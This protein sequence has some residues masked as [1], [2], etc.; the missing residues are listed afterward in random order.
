[1]RTTLTCCVLCL[2]F[3]VGMQTAA[4]QQYPDRTVR[5]I[6]GFGA[7][8]SADTTGR[9]VAQKLSERW[10]QQVIVDNR[11]GAAGVIGMQAAAKASRDG[12][13]LMIGSAT[14]FSVGPALG[15]GQ[16]QYP[17]ALELHP[18]RES[19]C[20]ANCV[21]CASVATGP[22][23]QRVHAVR[24]GPVWTDF[25]RIHGRGYTQRYSHDVNCPQRWLRHCSRALQ[26]RQRSHCR[27][28][29]VAK[30]Q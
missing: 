16:S 24:Q 26:G 14:Q 20:R 30:S 9:V 21:N 17:P 13:T 27:S 11:A 18:H 15:A 2:F 10:G 8:G 25:V 3:N 29:C 22:L 7:G 19:S 1:M 23:V 6:V 5:L 4:A 12:Y 28:G